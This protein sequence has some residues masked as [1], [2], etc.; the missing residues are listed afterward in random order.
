MRLADPCARYFVEPTVF[1]NVTDEMEIAQE[2]IFGP[3]Q[4]VRVYQSNL[5]FFDMICCQIIKF[6]TIEEVVEKANNSRYGLAG[7]VF[8]KDIDNVSCF[9]TAF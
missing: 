1:S 2:E 7:G 6:D 8:T 9:S 5:T 4:V 3:V